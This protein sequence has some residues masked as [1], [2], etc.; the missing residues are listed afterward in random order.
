MYNGIRR[1]NYYCRIP[2]AIPVRALVSPYSSDARLF[3]LIVHL[4]AS[5]L[6]TPRISNILNLCIIT[7]IVS[8]SFPTKYMSSQFPLPSRSMFTSSPTQSQW[9]SPKMLNLD[10]SG[11]N[12]QINP[13]LSCSSFYINFNRHSG[14]SKTGSGG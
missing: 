3:T 5:A 7:I 8:I 1:C 2:I 6:L 13:Y 4:T 11:I 9:S 10:I 12:Y 14:I